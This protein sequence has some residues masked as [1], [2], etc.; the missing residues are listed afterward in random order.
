MEPGSPPDPDELLRVLREA[1]GPPPL[2]PFTLAREATIGRRGPRHSLTAQ[3]RGLGVRL[4]AP[5]L[6]D[7]IG[8]LERDR[9]RQD[10]EIARLNERIS[11]LEHDR[12]P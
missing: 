2:P 10:A 6:L 1:A 8:Q 3:L 5:S 7:L 4:L 12:L 11:R 9:M